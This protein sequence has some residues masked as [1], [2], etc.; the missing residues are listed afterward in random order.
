[1]RARVLVHT[2]IFITGSLG[3]ENS[4]DAGQLSNLRRMEPSK[5]PDISHDLKQSGCT[6]SIEPQATSSTSL[7]QDGPLGIHSHES[8]Q[9]ILN[10][11][12]REDAIQSPTQAYQM[13]CQS[14]TPLED[15]RPRV[16]SHL[17]HRMPSNVASTS[18]QPNYSHFTANSQG[19]SATTHNPVAEGFDSAREA[20]VGR[21][22]RQN[23]EAIRRAIAEAREL[24]AREVEE[25]E[26]RRWKEDLYSILLIIKVAL[27]YYTLYQWF[28]A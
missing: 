3:L 9:Q 11:G 23:V 28:I 4:Q 27:I 21:P 25:A 6:Q 8:R 22:R 13:E 26:E 7:S 2:L 12:S 17:R 16:D 24:M 1:M 19:N 20:T 5:K 18:E 15:V 10:A 14:E